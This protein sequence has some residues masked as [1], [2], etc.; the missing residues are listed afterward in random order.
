LRALSA[1]I[2]KELPG[3]PGISTKGPF[4]MEL[5]FKDNKMWLFQVRPFVENKQAAASDY[6]KFITPQFDSNRS[7]ALDLKL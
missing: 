6:L 5:G 4:D 7:A 1:R 3:A 2:L